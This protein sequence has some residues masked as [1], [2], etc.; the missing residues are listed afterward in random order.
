MQRL[1]YS[2]RLQANSEKLELLRKT[3]LPFL[4]GSSGGAG[5]PQLAFIG[6]KIFLIVVKVGGTQVQLF[7]VASLASR[8]SSGQGGEN[9]QCN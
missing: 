9:R 8:G 7:E 6:W 4:Q 5:F 1:E 2:T 3:S